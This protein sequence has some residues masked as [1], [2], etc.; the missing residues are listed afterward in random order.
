M[1]MF[2]LLS[3]VSTVMGLVKGPL[4][5]IVDAYVSDIELRRK[6]KADLEASLLDHLSKSEELQQNVV[7]AEIK[8]EQWLTANWRP[9]LMLVLMGFLILVG[10]IIPTL[11]WIAGHPIPYQP[12]WNELPGGFWDFLSVGV[13]GYIG[14]R[15]LEKIS[16]QVFGAV[17]AKPRGK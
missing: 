12:R 10:F 16:G 3:I 5:T 17:A 2:P 11:D 14:G 4:S 7:V 15:S 9:I 1:K 13:G 6:L 8:S